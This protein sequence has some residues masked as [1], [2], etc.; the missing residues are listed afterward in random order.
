M[1]KGNFE[2]E[3]CRLIIKELKDNDLELQKQHQGMDNFRKYLEENPK[4]TDFLFEKY[5]KL[6]PS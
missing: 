3:K 6:I 5:K 1:L 2:E 4:I